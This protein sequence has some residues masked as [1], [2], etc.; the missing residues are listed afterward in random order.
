MTVNG[1][2]DILGSGDPRD[3]AAVSW[4]Y[5][6]GNG[7]EGAKFWLAVLTE[8]KNRGV[9]DVC[10]LVCDG[11]KG[12]PDSVSATWPLTT[13]QTCLLHLIRNTFR[14]ASRRDS[15]ALGKQLRPVYT[16]P[17]AAAAAERFDEFAGT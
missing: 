15:G 13:V 16:A 4:E 1:E 7:H 14:Y 17:S 9:E 11:L 8:I 10:I 5:G 12:L 3:R 6:A 2:R